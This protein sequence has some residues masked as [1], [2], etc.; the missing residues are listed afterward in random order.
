MLANQ[1]MFE[2]LIFL[3]PNLFQIYT[4][5]MDNPTLLILSSHAP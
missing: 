2:Q 5:Y 3:F 4:L 1:N